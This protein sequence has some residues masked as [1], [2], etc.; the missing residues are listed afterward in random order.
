MGWSIIF[1]RAVIPQFLQ[2]PVAWIWKNLRL[3]KWNSNVRNPPALFADCSKSPWASPLHMVPKKERSWWPCSVYCCLNLLTTLDKY[4]LPNMQDLSNCLHG[5]NVFS[6]LNLVKGYHKISIAAAD[7][8]KTSIITPF[9]LF[10]YLFT[11]FGLSNAAQTY[12]SIRGV[13]IH[14]RLL[15]RFS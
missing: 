6:K 13:Y 15:C 14:G 7:I 4:P 5:C 9:G 3:Q 2:N 12:H 1:T 10:E 11:L 8:L